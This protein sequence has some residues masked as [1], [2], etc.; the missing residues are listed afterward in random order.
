MIKRNRREET[1]SKIVIKLIL[2]AIIIILIV[3]IFNIN[4]MRH[5]DG[6]DAI[7]TAMA[8][9]QTQIKTTETES[10][11][12]S[13][14]ESETESESEENTQSDSE[15]NET[16][17]AEPVPESDS[18]DDDYFEDAV[19]I[20]DSR[21]EGMLL[22]TGLSDT[23]SYAD[24]GLTVDTVFSLPVVKKEG[25]KIPIM[26]AMRETDFKKVYIM[27]GINETGWA[28]SKLFIEKYSKIIDEVKDINPNAI[29]YI[30]EILPVTQ[31]VSK[32]HSYIKNDKISEYN[33]LLRKLAKD[34]DVYFIDV[35]KAVSDDNG[36]LPE[37]AATDGVH[38][39][40]SYC[41]KWLDYLKTHTVSE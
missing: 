4:N 32:T 17:Y 35:G 38:L 23:I 5:K 16:E 10:E 27:F 1:Q 31:T 40:K 34:E 13:E 24:K 12:E 25:K 9:S 28:Y 26:D 20:G 8:V 6:K 2:F 18:V 22:F 11:L 19:F 3:V 33:K 37:D 30:Q 15:M 14:T 29:I 7:D 41:I 39:K 21:T 36:C